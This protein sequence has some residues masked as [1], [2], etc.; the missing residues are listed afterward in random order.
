[1]STNVTGEF[2]TGLAEAGHLAT[3]EREFTT[4]RIEVTGAATAGGAGGGTVPGAGGL[5]APAGGGSPYK[6]P[7]SG[8]CRPGYTNVHGVCMPNVGPLQIS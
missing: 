7:R 8:R 1:M 4:L 3:F 6:A 5:P 2:L